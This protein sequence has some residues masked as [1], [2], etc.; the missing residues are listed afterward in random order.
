MGDVVTDVRRWLPDAS[1]YPYGNGVRKLVTLVDQDGFDL[2]NARLIADANQNPHPEH[3]FG[4]RV[5]S[6]WFSFSDGPAS[7]CSPGAIALFAAIHDVTTQDCLSIWAET[8]PTVRS[9]GLSVS[10]E[11]IPLPYRAALR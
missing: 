3:Q 4:N 7:T 5:L 6:G 9:L 8:Q 11:S 1:I 10:R 2:V